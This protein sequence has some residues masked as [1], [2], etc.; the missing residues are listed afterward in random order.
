MVS[1]PK[2]DD[3]ALEAGAVWIISLDKHETSASTGV[4]TMSANGLALVA[5]L[6][7]A[8][9]FGVVQWRRVRA[10]TKPA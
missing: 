9:G 4:P 1:A 6:V 2:D 8:L 7:L 3:G 10:A 5:L